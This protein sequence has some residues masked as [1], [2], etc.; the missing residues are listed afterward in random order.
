MVLR[1]IARVLSMEMSEG[2]YA[3]HMRC[4]EKDLEL[5]WVWQCPTM[6]MSFAWVTFLVGYMLLNPTDFP[7]RDRW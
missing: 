5:V 1:P 6:L 2:G 4:L 3:A 7:L